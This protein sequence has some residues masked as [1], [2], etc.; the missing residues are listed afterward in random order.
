[1]FHELDPAVLRA[2]RMQE[3]KDLAEWRARRLQ[4][5]RDWSD[6][7]KRAARQEQAARELEAAHKRWAEMAEEERAPLKLKSFFERVSVR[8]VAPPPRKKL[9]QRLWLWLRR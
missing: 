7:V 5:F 8:Q 2:Q 3:L 9:Y 6:P 1:M 4:A